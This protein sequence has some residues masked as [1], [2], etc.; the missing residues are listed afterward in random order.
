MQ[1]HVRNLSKNYLDDKGL[2]SVS[3][4]ISTGEMV[5]IIGHNGAGKS[6]LLK[7]LSGWILSDAGQI[8]FEDV[9]RKNKKLFCTRVGFVP[10]VPNLFD[11]FSVE[12]NLKLFSRLFQL[13]ASRVDEILEEFH[14]SRMR[15][16]KVGQLSKGLKQRVS[17]ARALLPNPSILLVDEPTS[18]LDFETTKDV[19]RLLC[20]MRDTGKT[21]VFTSHR[22]EEFKSIAN[23]ILALR[24]GHLVFDGST[25]DFFQSTLYQSLYKC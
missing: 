9:D 4:G 12:Y 6:T 8:K 21:I 5:A 7:M 25:S 3:F 24:E 20:T 14:L 10:E 22:L 1:I 13:P 17:L 19:C 16:T 23:R 11:F 15:K 18:G 2:K